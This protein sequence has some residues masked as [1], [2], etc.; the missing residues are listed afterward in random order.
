VSSSE[1][2]LPETLIEHCGSPAAVGL[3]SNNSLTG[4]PKASAILRKVLG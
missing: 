4:T 1:I 2:H 3:S